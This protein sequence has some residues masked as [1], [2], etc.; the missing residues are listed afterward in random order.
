MQLL[1]RDIAGCAKA[2]AQLLASLPGVTESIARRPSLLAGWS[3]GH[4]L[5]HLARNADSVVRRL[6][7][8]ARGEIVDQ[9][10]GG[11]EGRAAEIEAGAGR[12][13]AELISDVRR[14]VAAVDAVFASMPPEAWDRP[15]RDING[16]DLP[17]D[18]V[19]FHRWREVEVHLVDLGIGYTTSDWPDEFVDAWFPDLIARLQRTA[20]QRALMAWILGR[21][22]AP[23]VAPL[24]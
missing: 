3:V 14:S 24:G 10:V 2:H 22:A 16:V 20:D 6:Q 23:S 8:A 21:G 9:Y 13:A 7:G 4:V 19:P 17:V 11:W 5:T 18:I 12:P 1:A 15:S